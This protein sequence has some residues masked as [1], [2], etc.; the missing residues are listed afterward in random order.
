MER[1]SFEKISRL[2]EIS[3]QKWHHD[4]LLTIKN[5]HDLNHH[6]SPYN[7]PII[8][9]SL[10]SEVVEGEHFVAVDLPSLIPSGSSL[11]REAE[12]EATGS[13][14][15]DPHSVHATFIY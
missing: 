10:P 13:G 3:K 2:L 7:I 14:I 12:S 5:L 15:G 1:A 9:R 4:V 6:L 8:P 11:A